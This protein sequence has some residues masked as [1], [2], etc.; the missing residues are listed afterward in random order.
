MP[1]APS[2]RDA[3]GTYQPFWGTVEREEQTPVKL[4]D[5]DAPMRALVINLRDDV[6][7]PG[8]ERVLEVVP[9]DDAA[10][11]SLTSDALGSA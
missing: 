9:A 10:M 7:P 11:T 2:A 5:F 8:F 4:P 3:D 1:W 6:A